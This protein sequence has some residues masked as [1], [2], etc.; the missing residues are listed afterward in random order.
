[1]VVCIMKN[2]GA[3]NVLLNAHADP[4][5]VDEADGD[6]C[7]HYAIK[8][9]GICSNEVLQ[10]IIDHGVDVNATNKDNRTALI[11]ACSRKNEG[12]V[13]V[14]LN[15][16]A[17]PNISDDR[18][19]TP[20][21][22]ACQNGSLT[23]INA[24]LN[25]AA[26]SEMMD[27][28]GRACVHFVFYSGEHS[29][30][31]YIDHCTDV[32]EAKKMKHAVL[33]L[34]TLCNDCML[35]AMSVLLKSQMDPHIPINK[36]ISEQLLQDVTNLGA[37]LRVV[38]DDHENAA[39][40]WLF[41]NSRQRE[42]MNALLRAGADTTNADV[43]GDTCLHKV[44]H[45]EY[46]SLEYNH[47]TLQMLLDYG[48][49]VNATNKNHQ[50][51]YMLACNQGNIDAMCALVNAG[52]DPNI[53]DSWGNTGLHLLV[54]GGSSKH[55]LEAII[56]HGA[57]VNAV[58]NEGATALMLACE[59]GQKDAVNILLR[60]G[61]DTSIVDVHADTCLHIL[62]HR[63]CDQEILQMLL[64]HGAPVNA[65]NKNLQTAYM[66]ARKQK[67]IEVMHT[68]VIAGAGCCSSLKLQ[69]ILQWVNQSSR[70]N[71]VAPDTFS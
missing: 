64:D 6:T 66:L 5:I 30:Q 23:V 60:A 45:R 21:M 57:D 42:C 34:R 51:A 28:F 62:L 16:H 70:P 67:N 2:E 41:C 65:T 63:E 49:P 69:T 25:A 10:A 22:E 26:D 7:L 68:L 17:D 36:H 58:N 38:K 29:S 55:I 14:L 12:A 15:A 11:I 56:A 37:G 61:A 40:Q 8:C 31:A 13:N 53:T 4:N 32:R 50:T 52:A 44:L 1:M 48:V 43:F 18:N 47:E 71:T 20:L 19:V 35:Y 54:Q 59:T 33:V 46:L 3:I 27:N 39:A 24:L 9:P